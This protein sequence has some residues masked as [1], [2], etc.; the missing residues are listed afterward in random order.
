MGETNKQ[1]NKQKKKREKHKKDEWKAWRRRG[2]SLSH[3]MTRLNEA[4]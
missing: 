3:L 1:K 4:I 2:Q